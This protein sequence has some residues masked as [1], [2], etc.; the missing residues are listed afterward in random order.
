MS[1]YKVYYLL[2]YLICY[3]SKLLYGW[4][5]YEI[6]FYILLYSDYNRFSVTKITG[7]GTPWENCK[8]KQKILKTYRTFC[9]GYSETPREGVSYWFSRRSRWLSVTVT[10][11]EKGLFASVTRRGKS[12]LAKYIPHKRLRRRYINF[13]ENLSAW[14]LNPCEISFL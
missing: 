2:Q 5:Y 12:S 7:F 9:E 1:I 3:K 4:F 6:I 13:R 14:V 11:R 10:R 8:N